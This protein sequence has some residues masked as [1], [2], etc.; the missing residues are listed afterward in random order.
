M[1]EEVKTNQAQVETIFAMLSSGHRCI[2]M[3]RHSLILWGLTGGILCI[4]TDMFLPEEKFGNVVSHQSAVLIFLT[5]V[6]SGAALADFFYTRHLRHAKGETFPFVHA[7]ITKVWWLFLVMGV[8]FTFGSSYFGGW[9]MIY[10]V[11]LLLLGLGLFVHGLFSEQLLEW[12]GVLIILLGI[13]PLVLKVPYE[14]TRWLTASVYGLGLPALSLLLDGG[15]TRRPFRR[16]IQSLL[17]LLLVLIPPLV[18]QRFLKKHAASAVSSNIPVVSLQA[19]RKE[20]AADSSGIIVALPAGTRVPVKIAITGNIFKNEET[21]MPLMLS[22]PV[23]ISM[24]NGKPSGYFR[25]AGGE[26]QYYRHNLTIKGKGQKLN[27]EISPLE[28]PAVLNAGF[29]ISAEQ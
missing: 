18:A 7:Q 11:W 29:T 28:G 12:A 24:E 21:I 15:Q 13:V 4:V 1:A 10:G 26:W 14:L 23:D 19:F 8:L 6:L 16:L 5:I 22:Q 17:W 3:E 27:T 20:R 25:L 9:Y 2:R